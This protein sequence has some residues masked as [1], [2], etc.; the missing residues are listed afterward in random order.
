MNLE[1][2]PKHEDR[3]NLRALWTGRFK[4]RGRGNPTA[5]SAIIAECQEGESES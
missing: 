1:I 3:D 4:G 5:G 2:L